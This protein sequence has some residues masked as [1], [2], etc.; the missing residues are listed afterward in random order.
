MVSLA[1][2]HH[3]ILVEQQTPVNPMRVLGMLLIIAGVIILRRF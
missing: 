2:E 1:L 3:H